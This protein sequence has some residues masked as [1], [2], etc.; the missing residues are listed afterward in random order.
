[1]GSMTNSRYLPLTVVEVL[2]TVNT[3][4]TRM[5]V[6]SSQSIMVEMGLQ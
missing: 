6:V 2:V 4:L 5:D 1:M 3:R